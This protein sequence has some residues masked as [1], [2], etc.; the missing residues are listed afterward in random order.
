MVQLIHD[1]VLLHAAEAS[2]ICPRLT[3]RVRAVIAFQSHILA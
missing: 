3:Q 2:V 1:Q